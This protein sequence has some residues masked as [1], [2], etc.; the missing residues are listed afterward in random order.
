MCLRPKPVE[1]QDTSHEAANVA[2]YFY[3]EIEELD[4]SANQCSTALGLTLHG[5]LAVKASSPAGVMQ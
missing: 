4:F 2:F 1:I 3:S 5:I